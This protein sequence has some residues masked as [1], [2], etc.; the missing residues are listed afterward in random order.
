MKLVYANCETNVGAPN[1]STH[2]LK[3]GDAWDSDDP[4]V[5][6]R[7]ELFSDFP[8][9]VHTSR[10]VQVVEQATAAPGEKRRTR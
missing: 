10:G 3:V 7:P 1:G 5:K 2:Y 9:R 4:L 8:L 6:A